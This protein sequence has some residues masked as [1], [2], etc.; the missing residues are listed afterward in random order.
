MAR[1]LSNSPSAIASRKWRKEHLKKNPT[2][3]R[4]RARKEREKDPL[5]YFYRTKKANAKA[6]GIEFT[7]EFEDMPPMVKRCPILGIELDYYSTLEVPNKATL[8]RIDPS[9]GY[10]PGNV[11]WVSAKA[12]RMKDE[13]TIETLT[14]I[15]EYIKCHTE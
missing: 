1:V 11:A 3:Y 4:D 2:Y 7:L 10:V 14:A 6:Q 9:K 5:K 12:N 13:H 15:L 8:D